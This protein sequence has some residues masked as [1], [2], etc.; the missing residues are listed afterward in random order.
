[1]NQSRQ[2]THSGSS[3]GIRRPRAR[4]G[5]ASDRGG[6][7]A[8][9]MRMRDDA[10]ER[11]RARNRLEQHAPV[12]AV[13]HPPSLARL[14]CHGYRLARAQLSDL[15]PCLGRLRQP[16]H[17]R[18]GAR[19]GGRCRLVCRRR[20]AA[21]ALA[22]HRVE[23][24][25]DAHVGAV[26][27]A[28]VGAAR[29]RH[30]HVLLERVARG[31]LPHAHA[32]RLV[33]RV[34]KRAGRD[35]PRAHAPVGAHRADETVADMLCALRAWQWRRLSDARRAVRAEAVVRGCGR[36]PARLE[37]L[38]QVR[39]VARP[40]APRAHRRRQRRRG[41]RVRRHRVAPP[42][43]RTMELD[44]DEP[45]G[46]DRVPL[47]A[48][49]VARPDRAQVV[50]ACRVAHAPRRAGRGALR[51]VRATLLHFPV[52]VL[53][54]RARLIGG[55]PVHG[56]ARA[57][58]RGAREAEDQGHVRAVERSRTA[59]GVGSGVGGGRG[60]G[61]GG[62]GRGGGAGVPLSRRAAG[63][64]ALPLGR[65]RAVFRA[66]GARADDLARRRMGRSGGGGGGGGCMRGALSLK[67]ELELV[68]M[69][70]CGE[71]LRVHHCAELT[72][73]LLH[74]GELPRDIRIRLP[75]ERWSVRSP[76]GRVRLR[77]QL[78]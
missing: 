63:S 78:R 10:L 57:E 76:D 52:P 59:A 8:R 25:L 17:E 31:V 19:A 43:V 74:L 62:R 77:V 21:A 39:G 50:P 70:L 66:L 2:R 71:V 61:H 48:G 27:P 20:R 28:A 14:G 72:E 9:R 1:M 54:R 51:K 13:H 23:D 12:R 38:E 6:A 24:K 44:L 56:G 55:D 3:C 65:V 68:R 45:R 53:A 42:A 11:L 33:E 29:H 16:E 40:A 30:V 49:R 36:E 7:R 47:A 41:S 58:E 46:H 35:A 32:G 18:L 37:D 4:R 64:R 15:V 60:G 75:T 67:L 22:L 34:E 5:H 26:R 73:L 69:R